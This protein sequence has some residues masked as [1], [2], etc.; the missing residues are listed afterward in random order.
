LFQRRSNAVQGVFDILMVDDRNRY[1]PLE[2]RIVSKKSV[3]MI[4]NPLAGGGRAGKAAPRLEN[5]LRETFGDGASVH[6]TRFPGHAT[7]IAHQSGLDGAELIIAVGGDGTIQEVV[8][9]LYDDRRLINPQCE[10]GIIDYG[11]GRGLAQTLRLPPSPEEQFALMLEAGYVRLDVG[12]LT[13]RSVDNST[14]ERLFVSECQLGIG[15]EVAAGVGKAHK[16][17]GGKLAF[18]AAAVHQA[19]TFKP[20]D[21]KIRVDEDRLF[22]GRFIGLVIGNGSSCAGGMR[23][24]PQARPDDGVLDALLMHEMTIGQRLQGFTKVYS[25]AHLRSPKFSIERGRRFTV[26]AMQEVRVAA[27]GE[28]LGTTPC[29]CFLLGDRLRVKAKWPVTE[30]RHEQAWYEHLE[31]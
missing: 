29:T 21:L 24:T 26:D 8:N 14:E 16:R 20:F 10:L 27:D 5:L 23:L 15:A 4:L 11:T 22:N 17:A 30:G 19:L 9:G 31:V 3:H 25:G 1:Q 13:F 7:Q 28:L 18:G 12:C 2:R 6:V